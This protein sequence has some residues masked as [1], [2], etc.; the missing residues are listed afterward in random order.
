MSTLQKDGL[1]VR[2]ITWKSCA[3]CVMLCDGNGQT[4]GPPVTG[5]CTTITPLHVLLSSFRV[6]SPSTASNKSSTLLIHLIY[7]YQ[8][9][10]LSKT[11]E[12]PRDRRFDDVEDIKANTT[13]E[14]W[15]IPL[16][17]FG[18]CFDKWQQRWQK[19]VN[20]KGEY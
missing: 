7:L 12:L 2:S 6:S 10:S 16:E 13:M 19:C 8:I 1:L 11:E 4:C 20:S 17:E 3:V 14:L 9:F 5:I 18:K 15:S